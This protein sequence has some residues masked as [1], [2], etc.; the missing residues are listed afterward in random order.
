MRI[1]MVAAVVVLGL[2]VLPTTQAH[3]APV[4]VELRGIVS[5]LGG[6]HTSDFRLGEEIVASY[7]FETTTPDSANDDSNTGVFT[8]GLLQFS[9]L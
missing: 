3:A 9:M 7:T 8:G 2:S 1:P 5:A 4:T 6:W